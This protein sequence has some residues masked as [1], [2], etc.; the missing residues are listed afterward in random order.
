MPLAREKDVIHGRSPAKLRATF[1]FGIYSHPNACLKTTDVAI[2][3]HRLPDVRVSANG[4]VLRSQHLRTRGWGDAGA[5][6][7]Q[8][9]DLSKIKSVKAS[10]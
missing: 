9:G 6:P 4:R 2:G 8:P 3:I 1:G 5:S 7:S 10:R